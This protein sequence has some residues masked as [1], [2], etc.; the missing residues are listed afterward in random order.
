MIILFEEALPDFAGGLNS[1][2]HTTIRPHWD[3]DDA[4]A[5]AAFAL[6]VHELASYYWTGNEQ[7]IVQGAEVLLDSFAGKDTVDYSFAMGRG[8]CAYARGIAHLETL[9]YSK[10]CPGFFCNYSLGERIFK[11]LY[12]H[13]PES[14]FHQ[15]FLNLYLL[16]QHDDEDDHCE[17]ISAGICHLESAFK[18]GAPQET[19]AAVDEV[20]AR[21]Y[22]AT[23]PPDLSHQDNRPIEPNTAEHQRKSRPG[24]G[25]LRMLFG[26][27]RGQH[28]RGRSTERSY[29]NLML[30]SR[31][32]FR[33]RPA[34]VTIHSV[35][36]RDGFYF[37]SDDNDS[38]NV[39]G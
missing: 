1:K 17:G 37:N 8:P 5:D 35:V 9:A 11:S 31:I 23:E 30:L 22:H 34:N 13:L 20:I 2:T 21:L 29:I 12:W 33:I 27:V 39:T 36:R 26:A 6:H 10:G 15:G 14:A 24:V 38:I 4:A 19:A 32:A 28:I 3:E 25:Q 18:S 16:A 7:W